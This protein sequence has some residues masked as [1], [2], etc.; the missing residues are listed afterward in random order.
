MA[1]TTEERRQRADEM[2]EILVQI[3]TRISEVTGCEGPPADRQPLEG[4]VEE[5]GDLDTALR[6]VGAATRTA[7]QVIGTPVEP[8][9]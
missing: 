3:A 5:L 1:A 6:I 4:T 2:R 8:A 9:P 7:L